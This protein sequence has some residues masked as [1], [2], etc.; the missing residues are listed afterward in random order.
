MI[1]VKLLICIL[2]WIVA[3]KVCEGYPYEFMMPMYEENEDGK[4]KQYDYFHFY[5]TIYM[6]VFLII[7]LMF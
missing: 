2:L 5:S 3:H 1:I 4:P 6:I 7:I